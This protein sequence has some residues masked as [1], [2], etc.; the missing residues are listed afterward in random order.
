ML[1]PACAWQGP[2]KANGLGPERCLSYFFFLHIS[3]FLFFSFLFI[4]FLPFSSRVVFFSWCTYLPW[5]RIYRPTCSWCTVVA[6]YGWYGMVYHTDRSLYSSVLL[7]TGTAH[8]Y[9][10]HWYRIY[11]SVYVC[12][13]CVPHVIH[14]GIHK[15]FLAIFYWRRS[16][17]SVILRRECGC[18]SPPTISEYSSEVT[19]QFSWVENR[20]RF[21]GPSKKDQ[22]T[23]VYSSRASCTSMSNRFLRGLNNA[24]ARNTIYSEQKL[25][26]INQW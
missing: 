11:A 13:M 25:L 5:I 17:C 22:S 24:V 21:G 16:W 4:S 1:E 18:I 15:F 12:D 3:F 6:S 23:R 7:H 10:I 9:N 20:P 26:G 14:G 2:A 8:I 19:H